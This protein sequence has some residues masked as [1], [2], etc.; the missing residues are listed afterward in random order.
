MFVVLRPRARSGPFEG[1]AHAKPPALPGVPDWVTTP[2]LTRSTAVERWL[3]W[4]PGSTAAATFWLK[5]VERW[6]WE[7]TQ[8]RIHPGA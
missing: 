2:A 8:E 5:I 3:K 4:Y 1:P 6:F 7:I